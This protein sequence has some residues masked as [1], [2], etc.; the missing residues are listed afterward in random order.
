MFD[1]LTLN[2][3]VNADS[4]LSRASIVRD[5]EICCISREASLLARKEVLTGKAKFGIIGDGKEVPQVAMARAFKKGDWRSGYYRDQ[6]FLFALGLASVEDF[7]AQLYADPE[8]D[9][10]SGGRQ[11]NS[12]FATPTIGPNGEWADHMAAHNISSDISSTAGQMARALG[13]ALASKKYRESK[14]LAGESKFSNQGNEVCFCTIG[15]ASTSEGIFWETMN[16]A[17]VLQVPLAISVWD[18]G[19]GISVPIEY[20]TAKS[21]ISEALAGF[22]VDG[23][24]Q[25]GIEIYTAK[26]WDYPTL[27]KLYAEAIEKVRTSHTP[28]LLHIQEVTQPQG[29]STSGSHER[30]KSKERLK[31]EQEKDCIL[32]MGQWMI[33]EGIATREELDTISR[34]AKVYVKQCRDRAWKAFNAPVKEKLKSLQDLYSRISSDN[35]ATD[36]IRK[37]LKSLAS[38]LISE[39]A[40]NARRMYYQLMGSGHP[41]EQELAAW[42]KNVYQ[43]SGQRYHTHLYS[44]SPRSALKVPA[45]PARFPDTPNLKNGYEILNNFFDFALERYPEL[46]AFGEDVGKI[47]DVNQ[48]FAGMQKKYGE[49]RVFDTGIREATIMGQA[50]GMAMRG[51]RPIAEIQYLDYLIY[52]LQPLMDDLATL[53]YRSNGQQQAPAIIRTRGHRLEGI[54][55][56]GSPMGMAINALRGMYVCVPRN[57]TQAAGMYNTLLQSDDPALVVECLNGYRL[58]EPM[59]DNIGEYTVPLG[60]PEVLQ[61]GSDITL[62]TYG[63]CVRIAQAG[64]ELL[65]RQ[66]VSVELIDVQTLLPFDLEGRI[67]ESLKKTN[68]VLFMDEDVPGGASAFMMNEVLEKQDGYRYLDSAPATLTAHEHRPPYGSDGDY[69]SK[70]NPEDVFEAVYKIMRETNPE[71]FPGTFV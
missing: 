64:I 11:M 24:G 69:F 12:H 39:L 17:A 25:S 50:I 9:P 53:R 21:S 14:V 56:A 66:G 45:I 19:F 70:P 22:Q 16:A 20:Q 37:E 57:M 18:D 49:E 61:E 43:T 51:L 55:H 63:S 29:H 28:A 58:K 10:F 5:F 15:D 48:G 8:N 36:A 46:F 3:P 42:I 13:L 52:G 2:E 1:H 47:G 59:P 67:V 40:Q 60:V 38:P 35:G 32:L 65:K 71:R 4:E 27:V 23:E 41:A 68:R 31:W 7:F 62:V 54:W 30:Y 44:N 6:T 34:E 26:A 33:K